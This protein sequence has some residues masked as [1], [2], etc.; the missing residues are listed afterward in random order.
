MFS[1]KRVCQLAPVTSSANRH[2]A[3]IFAPAYKPAMNFAFRASL[4]WH[5]ERHGT[6]I[7]DLV[8]ATGV[9]RDVLN[10]LKAREDSSTTVENGILIAAYY[11]KSINQ[12]IAKAEVTQADR[13]RTLF[14]L[15]TPEE[16]TLLSAQIEGVLRRQQT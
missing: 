9:S 10:K 8:K 7:V 5:M 11:G 15:L 3:K 6:K 13:L 12:F 2:G 4:M 16:Q 14:E 1:M